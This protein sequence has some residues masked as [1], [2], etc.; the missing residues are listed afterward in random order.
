[1]GCDWKRRFNSAAYKKLS[2]RLGGW[3][4]LITAKACGSLRRFHITS[5]TAMENTSFPVGIAPR[6]LQFGRIFAK[7][8]DL[9]GA[10]VGDQILRLAQVLKEGFLVLVVLELLDQL[11]D[12]VFTC[13]ILLFNCRKWYAIANS[14]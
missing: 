6:T 7:S 1:M 9:G 12:L 11:L 2:H 14:L 10:H 8:E 4:G 13:C 3:A 5:T